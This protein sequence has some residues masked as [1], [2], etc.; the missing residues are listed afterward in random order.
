MPK[1]DTPPAEI[2]AVLAN[3]ALANQILNNNLQQQIIIANQHAMNQIMMAVTAKSVSL[4]LNESSV[5]SSTSGES[6][7]AM[8]KELLGLLKSSQAPAIPPLPS[9]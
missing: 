9:N 1:P 8:V 7:L 2:P 4:I 3:L 5:Q 6:N